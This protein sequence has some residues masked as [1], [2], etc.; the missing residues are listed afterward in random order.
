M[1]EAKPTQIT[2]NNTIKFLI[3]ITPCGSISFLSKCWG[4]RVSDKVLTQNSKF[5]SHIEQGDVILADRGFT[6]ADDIG[7][8]GGK[9]ETP[10]FTRGKKQLSQHDVEHSKQLSSVRIHVE[11]VIEQLR[12]KFHILKGPIAIN[13]LR[14]KNDAE[15][16]NIDKILFVCAALCNLTKS[17]I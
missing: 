6:I 12:K 4:G 3:G 17:V 10:S 13:L 14:Q 11:R 7:L 1:L 2:K 16:A 9:L 5:L 8:C 15:V